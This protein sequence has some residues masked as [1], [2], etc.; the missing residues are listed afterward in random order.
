MRS[1]RHSFASK[2]LRAVCRYGWLSLAAVPV[3]IV[4]VAVGGRGGSPSTIAVGKNPVAVALTSGGA[5]AYVVNETS[6]TVT[7]VNLATGRTGRPIPVNADIG[8]SLGGP[9]AIAIT[10][11]GATAYIADPPTDT[12]VPVDLASGTTG[13]PIHI[14][15]GPG[16]IAMAPDGRIVYVVAGSESVVPVSVRTGAA[17][18]PIPVGPHAGWIAIAPDGA[19]AYVTSFSRTWSG[20]RWHNRGGKVTP[21]NLASG[22]AGKPIPVGGA[23]SDIAIAP[24]GR[25]AYVINTDDINTIVPVNLATR[26]PGEPI[27]DPDGP[28]AIA[29]APDGATAYITNSS[30]NK[31]HDQ[32]G[33]VTPLTLAT[34][35]LG[36][37]IPVGGDPE[38]IAITPQ[39]K[40]ACVVNFNDDTMSVIRLNH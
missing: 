40:A 15:G 13:K 8:T 14:A 12:L 34:T 9:D 21:V 35:T 1:H 2:G 7:P 3:V 36:K 23:P 4:G 29:I 16:D 31:S 37:P 18:K 32:D 22:T 28:G 11:N 38:A 27:A 20:G 17:G 5:K 19:T 39:G 26:I 25:T 10:P 33:S 6:N 24:D 30:G